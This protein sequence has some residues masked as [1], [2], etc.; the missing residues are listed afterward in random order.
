MKV[1]EVEKMRVAGDDEF[2]VR[3]KRARQHR[4][5]VRIARNNGVDFGGKPDKT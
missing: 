1:L 5:I 4:V 2:G 3:T